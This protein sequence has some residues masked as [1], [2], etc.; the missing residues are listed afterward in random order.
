MGAVFV[1]QADVPACAQFDAAAASVKTFV[2]TKTVP[3]ADKLKV[4]GLFKQ[5]TVG[6]C[7][8]AR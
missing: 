4:Y 1:R 8:T 3:D 2:P 5:A 7:N 6:D